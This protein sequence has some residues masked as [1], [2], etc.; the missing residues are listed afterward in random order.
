M[1]TSIQTKILM[2]V[3]DVSFD[4]KMMVGLLKRAGYE[5]VAFETAEAAWVYLQDPAHKPG[6]IILDIILPGDSGLN[7][8]RKIRASER[9]A[10]TPVIFCSSKDKDTDRFWALRQGGN[11]YVTKPFTPM[12]LLETVKKYV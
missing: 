3:E 5:V 4:Q 12:Q 7:L 2:L 11:D 1:Q 9:F 8:C 10:E 6:A